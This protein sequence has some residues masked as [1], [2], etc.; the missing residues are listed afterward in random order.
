MLHFKNVIKPLWVPR[1]LHNEIPEIAIIIVNVII[2]IVLKELVFLLEWNLKWGGGKELLKPRLCML[3]SI[4]CIA[5]WSPSL[6]FLRMYHLF[7]NFPL[8]HA[9]FV[10]KRSPILVIPHQ[11][12]AKEVGV[13]SDLSHLKHVWGQR[14]W[15]ALEWLRICLAVR[16]QVAETTHL[17]NEQGST[18]QWLSVAPPSS[19]LERLPTLHNFQLKTS[20]RLHV[21]QSSKL[22]CNVAASRTPSWPQGHPNFS[23]FSLGWAMFQ[24]SRPGFS[25]PRAGSLPLLRLQQPQAINLYTWNLSSPDTAR[26]RG[27]DRASGGT[28]PNRLPRQ[29]SGRVALAPPPPLPKAAR[30]RQAASLEP[31]SHPP[32]HAA[33][34]GGPAEETAATAADRRQKGRLIPREWRREM[35]ISPPRAMLHESSNPTSSEIR[36]DRE[37]SRWYGRRQ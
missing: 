22:V 3:S 21:P 17:G 30:R 16:P 9:E 28:A 6:I 15:K 29:T 35:P 8:N 14:I 31:R 26:L 4:I 1:S 34:G 25:S 11:I 37:C 20:S 19:R 12:I 27:G 7:S 18:T 23:I 10:M 32:P 5:T 36:G 33:S 24:V 13:A 2:R